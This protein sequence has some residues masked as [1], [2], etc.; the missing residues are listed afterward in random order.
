MVAWAFVKGITAALT[1]TALDK[2]LLWGNNSDIYPMTTVG[3]N[4]VNGVS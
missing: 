3:A 4:G 2:R 1:N